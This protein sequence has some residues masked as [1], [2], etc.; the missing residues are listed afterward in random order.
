MSAA[1]WRSLWVRFAVARAN[2]W[3]LS[4]LLPDLINDVLKGDTSYADA[5]KDIGVFLIGFG[6]CLV[7]GLLFLLCYPLIG[8]CFCCCRLCGNCGGK[9]VHKQPSRG[10]CCC[11]IVTMDIAI[12]FVL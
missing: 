1:S 9:R 10:K 2:C 8:C 5:G 12:T 11:F 7:V 4:A 3:C 6:I